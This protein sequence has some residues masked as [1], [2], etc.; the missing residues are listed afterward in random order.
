MKFKFLG[1]QSELDV[2][3]RLWG[4]ENAEFL[5]L[6]GRRRV[7][8][9]ALLTE[10]IQRT[11]HRAL[12]WVASP[13][14]TALQ[15]KSF[16]Q[17]VYN[18]ANPSNPAPDNFTYAAWEQAFQQVANLAEKQR[19]ALF[20]DEFTYLLEV[21][22][23]ISGLLQ[24]LWDHLLSKRNLFLVLSGSHLGM[25]KREFLSY[26]APLY[27]RASSQLHLQPFSFGATRQFF[28]KYSAVDRVAIYTMFGGVPAYLER[29]DPSKSI[30]QNIRSQLLTPNNLLQAEPRLL[31]QDFVTEPH[32]YIAILNA[33]ANGAHTIKEIVAVAGLPTGHVNKNLSVLMETGFVERRVPITEEKPSRSGRYHITDPYL[34]FY[35]RF[36]A[37][38]Q[39][40]LALGIQ[41]QALAEI[42]KHMINFIGQYTWEELCREWTLRAGAAKELPFLP[43]KVGSAWNTEAQV[44]VVGINSMNKTLILGE[45]KW[46]TTPNDRR[47]VAELIEEKA[48]NIIPTR[49]KWKVFF[50][51]F[52]RGGWTSGA[53]AYQIEISKQP[54]AGQNWISTGLRLVELDQLDQDLARWSR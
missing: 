53:R 8:K 40:Q 27:G 46:T 24:N 49:G 54:V 50:L 21:D 1:R 23:G 34:R 44:D 16:S 15:L 2:L 5:I 29:L 18:F 45:C 41:D 17:A 39:D 12:Y 43:D 47:P 14:S 19:L 48:P 22:P 20:V 52:S 10:W 42:S 36:L 13:T 3:N 26:Q 33:I 11:S 51:A 37:G 9:T 28:P 38:R 4:S 31:L 30:S 25:M 35:F 6:F 7:G 32:N